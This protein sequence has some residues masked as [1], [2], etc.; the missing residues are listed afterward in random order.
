[1]DPGFFFLSVAKLTQKIELH[2]FELATLQ[3]SFVEIRIHFDIGS[4]IHVKPPIV[5]L[6][7]RGDT[8]ALL[9]THQCFL[10]WIFGMMLVPM[11]MIDM[12]Q[13]L[14]QQQWY[15]GQ[16]DLVSKELQY[17]T[18]IAFWFFFCLVENNFKPLA[19]SVH[20]YICN[21]CSLFRKDFLYQ[22]SR[23]TV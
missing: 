1:M 17:L 21:F 19:G 5:A 2:I 11:P 15:D 3:F 16:K 20:T 10:L 23:H 14:T 8:S 6:F 18:P 9:L 22:T 13:Q 4:H 7:L 12:I